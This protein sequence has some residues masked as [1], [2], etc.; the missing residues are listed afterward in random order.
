MRYQYMS[1]DVRGLIGWWTGNHNIASAK[2][3][4]F[5]SLHIYAI[6]DEVTMR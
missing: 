6:C 1:L 3:K 5:W 2:D 4:G